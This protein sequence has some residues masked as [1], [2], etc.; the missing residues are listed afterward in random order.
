MEVIKGLYKTYLLGCDGQAPLGKSVPKV[1]QKCPK[2][3]KKRVQNGTKMD[4][5]GTR[6]VPEWYQNSR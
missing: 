5:N 3:H 1:M 4:Q 6:M 2:S